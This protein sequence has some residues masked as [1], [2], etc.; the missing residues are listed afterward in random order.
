[1]VFVCTTEL[2][3][4]LWTV[5]RSSIILSQLLLTSNCSP[6]K[7]TYF[8]DFVLLRALQMCS[9][10]DVVYCKNNVQSIRALKTLYYT[11]WKTIYERSSPTLYCYV[12]SESD[13]K[14]LK[15]R[16]WEAN[17]HVIHDLKLGSKLCDIF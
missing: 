3:A 6:S 14:V 7:E 11:S 1:M 4:A 17:S 10:E 12:I 8:D 5:S 2:I 13:R 16:L 15:N 9:T